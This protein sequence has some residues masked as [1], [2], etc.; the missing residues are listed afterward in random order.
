MTIGWKNN[1]IRFFFKRNDNLCFNL[2]LLTTYN[3]NFLNFILKSLYLLTGT[4]DP[5]T[6]N[7][8]I[9]IFEFKSIIL[10]IIYI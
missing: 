1:S 2:S 9:D 4:L 6:F 7:G 10:L 3:V 8:V 5:F